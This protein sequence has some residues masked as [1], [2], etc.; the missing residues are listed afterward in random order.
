MTMKKI[1]WLLVVGCVT[2]LTSCLKSGL[3][4]IENSDL[5]ELSSIT[6]EYRWLTKNANGYDQ[7][8]RQQLTL[9]RNTP[10]EN[11]E[12]HLSITV[13]P[14]SSSFPS[15]VRKDVQL[16]GLYLTAVISSA[17]KITPLGDAPTMGKRGSFEL[18]K[19][20]KYLVTAA[21]GNSTVYTIVIDDFVNYQSG[22]YRSTLT[23]RDVIYHTGT[24][25][26]CDY[27]SENASGSAL[28]EMGKNPDYKGNENAKSFALWDC[29]SGDMVI[30]KADLTDAARYVLG[31]ATATSNSGVKCNVEVSRDLETL[32]DASSL[33]A[34]HTQNIVNNGKW[35]N[36]DNKLT[37][38]GYSVTEPGTYYIRVVLLNDAGTGGTACLKFLELYN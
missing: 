26:P 11:N 17:A 35:N 23:C 25:N 38:S 18:G 1:I 16:D 6:M 12:I 7:L 30:F 13:P 31:C 20:Y 14:M 3:D 21:N 9:S 28:G 32:K 34:S 4:D 27:A 8:A 24:S 29:T 10:D 33:D 2:L 15:D 22:T 36:F 37:F 5:C 19:E